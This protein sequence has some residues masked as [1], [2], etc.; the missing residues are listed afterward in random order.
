MVTGRMGTAKQVR[1]YKCIPFPPTI[2]PLTKDAHNTVLLA[3]SQ[4][5]STA[6]SNITKTSHPTDSG[7]SGKHDDVMPVIDPDLQAAEVGT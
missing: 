4:G 3:P 5:A 6:T 2:S 7:D 1:I